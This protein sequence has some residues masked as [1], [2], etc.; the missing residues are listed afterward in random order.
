M[1]MLWREKYPQRPVV[2]LHAYALTWTISAKECM[3]FIFYYACSQLVLVTFDGQLIQVLLHPHINN[4]FWFLRFKCFFLTM[5]HTINIISIWNL[6]CGMYF[7]DER[8]MDVQYDK[9]TWKI[10]WELFTS[11]VYEGHLLLSE[12]NVIISKETSTENMQYYML[13]W[14][15]KK[16]ISNN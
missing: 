7:F 2:K 15:E 8:E 16:F 4:I 3:Y 6:K 10:P 9:V 14:Q 13:F 1:P 12:L 11:C 5:W